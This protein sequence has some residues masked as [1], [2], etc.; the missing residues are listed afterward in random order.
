[1]STMQH[2]DIAVPSV[3]H[4]PV[5]HQN[6]ET[7]H[8]IMALSDGERNL[9]YLFDKILTGLPITGWT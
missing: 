3:T 8:R 5:L 9:A 4:A 7:Y 6:D 1:M 2:S